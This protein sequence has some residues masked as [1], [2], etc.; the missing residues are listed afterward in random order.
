MWDLQSM[1]ESGLSFAVNNG[2]AALARWVV[3]PEVPWVLIERHWP[4]SYGFHEMRLP[5]SPLSLEQPLRVRARGV[6]MDLLFRTSE[7]LEVVDEFEAAADGGLLLAQLDA[8]PKNHVRLFDKLNDSTMTRQSSTEMKRGLG[9]RLLLDVP[10]SG[11]VSVISG[12]DP[13]DVR[14]AWERVRDARA[15]G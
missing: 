2:S 1:H 5:L 8:E 10:H 15:T 7:F 13:S 4:V 12:L 11:E 14:H 6:E 9:V 3:D